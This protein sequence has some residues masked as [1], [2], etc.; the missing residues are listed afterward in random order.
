MAIGNRQSSSGAAPVVSV[1]GSN[2][3]PRGQAEY[4]TALAVGRTLAEL[5][6]TVANGGYVARADDSDE[7]P[8]YFKACKPA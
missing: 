1:F 3:A 5:G 6:Y 2:D 4:R 8:R 7:L